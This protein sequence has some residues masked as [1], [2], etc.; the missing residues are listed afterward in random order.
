MELKDLIA[1]TL[2]FQRT[3][4]KRPLTPNEVWIRVQIH[5]KENIEELCCRIFEEFYGNTIHSYMMLKK[6]GLTNQLL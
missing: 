2:G 5:Q 6:G 1:D 4:A 3:N